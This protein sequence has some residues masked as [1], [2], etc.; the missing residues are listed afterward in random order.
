MASLPRSCAFTE[1]QQVQVWNEVLDN[2]NTGE[3][4]SDNYSISD[5]SIQ[6]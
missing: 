2:E 4:S 3:F 6:S 1:L 5:S